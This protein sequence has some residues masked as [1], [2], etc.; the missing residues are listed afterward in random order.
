MCDGS[1]IQYPSHKLTLGSDPHSSLMCFVVFLNNNMFFLGKNRH[2]PK[3]QKIGT[4]TTSILMDFGPLFHHFFVRNPQPGLPGREWCL[5]GMLEP[6]NPAVSTR[7]REKRGPRARWDGR[8][9]N[10]YG[11]LFRDL[12]LYLY[13]LY[14]IMLLYFIALYYIILYF[15]HILYYIILCY[16]IFYC[17]ILYYIIFLS[18]YIILYFI[19]LYY[20]IF[21]SYY[22]ILYFIIFYYIILYYII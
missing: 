13:I 21:L 6:P 2:W 1:H 15:Y 12:Y 8:S 18:Y 19:I 11:Y 14:Y 9:Y 4:K 20:I 16:I 5:C 3:V 10:G 17:I 22:I 7:F